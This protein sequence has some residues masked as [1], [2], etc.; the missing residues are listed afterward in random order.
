MQIRIDR[1]SWMYGGKNLDFFGVQSMSDQIDR[2]WRL[3]A[4]QLGPALRMTSL[5]LGFGRQMRQHGKNARGLLNALRFG[6]L[7]LVGTSLVLIGPIV[8]GQDS[9]G[10]GAVELDLNDQAH[11]QVVV[12]REPG[13]YLGH[14]TTVLLEDGKTILCVYPK[15]HGAG[16]IVYKRSRDGGLTWS[17]R[18]PTPANWATSKETP[19]IHRV[20]GPDGA[21]RLIMFSGL[22]PA[23]LAASE[24]DG[25]TWSELQP[26]GDWGGIV[27]MSSVVPLR[28]GPGHY[29]A[30]F[31]DDG[32]Y[33]SQ[34]G[35]QT[36]PITFKLLSSSSKDGGRTWGTPRVILE[37]TRTHLCEPGVIR[38]P[39]GKELLA[40][41]RENRRLEPSQ[42]IQS[43]D[44]G[45]SWSEPQPLP[46]SL[47][48]DRHVGRYSADGRLVISFR[49]VVPKGHQSAFQGDWVCWVG[50]Y[51]DIVQGRPGQY[52]IR[53]KDNLKGFDCAY[54]GVEVLPDDTFVVTTYGHWEQD[55]SPYILSVR[56]KLSELD[57]LA[58][59]RAAGSR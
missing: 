49:R 10:K 36:D 50:E 15:G 43:A 22:Y 30:M 21:R 16:A 24:D 23:R 38:S 51:E 9:A 54:P 17:E 47:W 44:D 32:R 14:P 4:S 20:V 46:S 41:L 53:L 48:G 58:K 45:D 13:Q 31:H 33:L 34:N 55:Q 18:L 12:D 40:L 19:T 29:L 28:T 57:E 37:S 59:T 1:E 42:W 26:V 52:L 3:S 56:F 35:K 2:D 25:E 5:N 6:W 11:R 7:C 39:D 8:H 27:V